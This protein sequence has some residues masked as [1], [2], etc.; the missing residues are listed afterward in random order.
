MLLSVSLFWPFIV[1]HNDLQFGLL[2]ILYLHV[3]REN[4]VAS[5]VR[6]ALVKA[7]TH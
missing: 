1:P 2:H 7:V 6:M 4:F 3:N 5:E